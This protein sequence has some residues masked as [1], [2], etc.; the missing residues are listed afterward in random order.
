MHPGA[1]PGHEGDTPLRGLKALIRG[2]GGRRAPTLAEPDG[3]ARGDRAAIEEL[4]HRI[5]HLEHVVEALQDAVHRQ[6][7]RLDQEQDE[8]RERTRP[9]EIARALSADARRR[10]L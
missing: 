7:T 6:W 8:I 1:Q 3:A 9:G 2:V 4:R 10:G 5:T